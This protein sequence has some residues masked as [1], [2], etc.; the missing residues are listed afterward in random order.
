VATILK[1][2]DGELG[3]VL[4]FP[5]RQPSEKPLRPHRAYVKKRAAKIGAKVAA[6]KLKLSMKRTN[7]RVR[8]P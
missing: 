1:F 8:R 2:P 6:S 3:T 4:T 7:T 5:N